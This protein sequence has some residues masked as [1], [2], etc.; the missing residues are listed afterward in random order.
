MN[1]WYRLCLALE[2]ERDE[3]QAELQRIRGHVEEA[4]KWRDA[5]VNTS[6]PYPEHP[7]VIAWHGAWGGLKAELEQALKEPE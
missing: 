4:M 7:K 1:R 5:L 3:L 6:V 2:S